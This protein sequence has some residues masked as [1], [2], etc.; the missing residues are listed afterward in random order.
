MY[1]VWCYQELNGRRIHQ[2]PNEELLLGGGGS[3]WL[4]SGWISRL[5]A[6]QYAYG[7]RGRNDMQARAGRV[8]RKWLS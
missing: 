7:G 5:M 1:T 2:W 3:E 4:R 8:P 6:V